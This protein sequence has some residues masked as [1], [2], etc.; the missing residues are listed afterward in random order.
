MNVFV[1]LLSSDA[2]ALDSHFPALTM[3]TTTGFVRQVGRKELSLGTTFLV[4]KTITLRPE[5]TTKHKVV[6]A[7]LS[8]IPRLIYT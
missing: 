1:R 5:I 6:L 3:I 2:V 7:H 8:K 4:R